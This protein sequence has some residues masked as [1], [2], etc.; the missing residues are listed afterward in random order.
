MP[1]FRR[2]LAAAV[3]RIAAD[4]RARAKAAEVYENEVKPRAEAA[5]QKNKPKVE[6]A[7]Q[8]NKPKVEAKAADLKEYA[9]KKATRENLEKLA[10]K[11]K[12]RVAMASQQ[13]KK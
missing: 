12:Q 9:R 8:Q 5:W 10:D 4:P 1:L 2:L 13:R 7:W 3:Q 11:V 6:A